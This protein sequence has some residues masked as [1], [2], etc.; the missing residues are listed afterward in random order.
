MV[1][2]LGARQRCDYVIEKELPLYLYLYP[3]YTRYPLAVYCRLLLYFCFVL[4]FLCFSFIS[5]FCGFSANVHVY[6]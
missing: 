1:E 4:N 3:Y 5:P 6:I 2:P